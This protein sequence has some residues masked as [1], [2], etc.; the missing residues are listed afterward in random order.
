MDV[1]QMLAH[2]TAGFAM[3]RGEITP[4]RLRLGRL[5]GP[6]AK[7]SL[8][9]RGE[10]MRRNSPSTPGM[11][12][13][14]ARDFAAERARLVGAVGRFVT[15]GPAGCTTHP[16]LFFGPLTPTEWATLMHQHLDH[17]LRQFRA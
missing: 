14:D 11:I 3:A 2:C 15:E 17:H 16:H 9:V 5:L 10:T 8:L 4:P 7:R 13:D 6:V 12:V 1:A